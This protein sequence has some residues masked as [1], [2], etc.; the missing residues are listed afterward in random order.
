MGLGRLLKSSR[1]LL[2]VGLGGLLAIV[3][4]MAW[5]GSRVVG[6]IE[7]EG[8]RLRA[9]YQQRDELLDGIR[10]A[11]SESA[12]DIRDYLADRNVSAVAQ[13]RIDLQKLR[14][15]I[16]DAVARYGRDLPPDEAA[17]W[18][19][20]TRDIEAYWNALEPSF[21]W[22]TQT[23]RRRAEDFLNDEVIPRH[24]ALLGLTSTIDRVNR[25]NLR[26]SNRRIAQLYA[27]FR[28]EMA[29]AALVAFLLGSLLAF[30]TIGK[31]LGLERASETQLGEVSRAR[32]ELRRFSHRLVEVQEQERRR[33][34]RE[35]HDEVGQAISAVLVELGRLE[36]ELPAIV[37]WKTAM[38]YSRPASAKSC[39]S[40]PRAKAIRKWP[41]RSRSAS[42]PSKPTVAT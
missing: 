1:A 3:L 20:L 14:S 37:T 19:Q 16:A 26:Q 32:L 39:S 9:T 29:L 30:F 4:L 42:T 28:T 34:A 22:D 33:V 11:L 31:I 15:R 36:K 41:H 35:L 38:T 5:E 7:G 40:S 25:R 17:L 13:R 18:S 8:N 23:R 21:H 24:G 2:W 12:S 10:F 27:Q 6:V